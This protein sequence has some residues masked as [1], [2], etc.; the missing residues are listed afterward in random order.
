M[1]TIRKPMY[2]YAC[3][4]VVRS[5]RYHPGAAYNGRALR[6]WVIVLSEYSSPYLQGSLQVWSFYSS[7]E[8]RV[9]QPAHIVNL[10]V[11][12]P[13]AGLHAEAHNFGY[14]WL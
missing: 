6:N 12:T 7:L 3:S 1:I 5:S 9:I 4:I 8:T 10:L 13:I 2:R 14:A 11:A